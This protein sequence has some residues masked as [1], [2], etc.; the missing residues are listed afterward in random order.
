MPRTGYAD[1][2]PLLTQESLPLSTWGLSVPPYLPL[3]PFIQPHWGQADLSKAACGG[4]TSSTFHPSLLLCPEPEMQKSNLLSPHL[5]VSKPDQAHE[6]PESPESPREPLSLSGTDFS[7]RLLHLEDAVPLPTLLLPGLCLHSASRPS[8]TCT[9]PVAQHLGAGASVPTSAD[10]CVY[11]RQM[12]NRHLPVYG[13]S[14]EKELRAL[15]ALEPVLDANL[16]PPVT[17]L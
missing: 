9:S 12:L 17:N 4:P 11:P 3:V 1:A 13:D 16:S 10:P 2:R 8:W 6:S 14:P 5:H 15:T 7:D